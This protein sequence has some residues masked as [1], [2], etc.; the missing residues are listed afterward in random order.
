MTCRGAGKSTRTSSTLKTMQ[1]MRTTPLLSST[2]GFLL[3]LRILLDTVL[4]WLEFPFVK[5][6]LRPS[7]ASFHSSFLSHAVRDGMGFR[8]IGTGEGRAAFCQALLRFSDSRQRLDISSPHSNHD[9]AVTGEPETCCE[10]SQQRQHESVYGG[11]CS[12]LSWMLT[13]RFRGTLFLTASGALLSS[14]WSGHV[15]VR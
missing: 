1:M 3:C 14:S 12:G 15:E 8:E 9:S 5:L 11:V 13:A 7:C 2:P 4:L 10:G 6:P